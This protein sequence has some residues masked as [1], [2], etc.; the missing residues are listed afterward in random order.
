MAPPMAGAAS[1]VLRDYRFDH[2][3]LIFMEKCLDN[4]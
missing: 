4:P 1:P 2:Y 3:D